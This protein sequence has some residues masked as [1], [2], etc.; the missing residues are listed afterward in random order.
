MKKNSS[1]SRIKFL[2]LVVCL[3]ISPTGHSLETLVDVYYLSS[4]LAA[5]NK[6]FQPGGYEVMYDTANV[7]NIKRPMF[8]ENS[9]SLGYVNVEIKIEEN[10]IIGNE[11]FSPNSLS[12]TCFDQLSG[13]HKLGTI[14]TFDDFTISKDAHVYTYQSLIVVTK[15]LRYSCRV[16]NTVSPHLFSVYLDGRGHSLVTRE[17]YDINEKNLKLSQLFRAGT[18]PVYTSYSTW[19][20]FSKG[21]VLDEDQYQQMLLEAPEIHVGSFSSVI[22]TSRKCKSLPTKAADAQKY[23]TCTK[24]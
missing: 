2:I 10:Q 3:L 9:G 1:R 18:G 22:C 23:W 14:L 17:F 12:K 20:L 13:E 5:L 24:E 11:C 19:G 15:K 8:Y 21:I 4:N 7:S 16:G 6:S